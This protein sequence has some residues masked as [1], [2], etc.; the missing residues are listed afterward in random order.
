[1]GEKRYLAPR[2][3]RNQPLKVEVPTPRFNAVSGQPRF[4]EDALWMSLSLG[5]YIVIS[6]EPSLEECFQFASSTA[7]QSCNGGQLVSYHG[8]DWIFD[9]KFHPV[10]WISEGFIPF[11]KVKVRVPGTLSGYFREMKLGELWWI[12]PDIP[13]AKLAGEHWKMNKKL[14]I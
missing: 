8:H 12:H 9:T 10:R 5:H 1:M 2:K 3:W 13:S 7:T 11:R 6:I 4:L 14:V